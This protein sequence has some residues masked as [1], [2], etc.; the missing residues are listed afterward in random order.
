MS[1]IIARSPLR[2][3][4]GG[5]GTDLQSYYSK[6]GSHFVSAAISKFTYVIVKDSFLPGIHLKYSQQESCNTIDEVRHPLFREC[7]RVADIE[8]PRIEITSLADI[9]SGTGLGS[10]G[11]FTTAL[12]KALHAYKGIDIS[13]YELAD[14]AA[15]VEMKILGDPVGKQDPFISVFAGISSF[16]IDFEGRVEVSPLKLHTATLVQ[17]EENLHMF[18]TGITR[19]AKDILKDQE[20]KSNELEVQENLHSVKA[21]GFESKSLLEQGNIKEFA[22]NMTTQWE[23]KKNRSQFAS[24]THIDEAFQ[25]GLKSGAIGGKLIGAGGGGFLLFYAENSSRLRMA[26]AGVGL[27]EVK[28]QFEFQGTK[29]LVPK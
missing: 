27:L 13:N 3:S 12:L 8:N 10:S 15:L 6:F 20:L 14:L 5:G 24:T 9:P 21:L 1:L 28:F 25:L 2:I 26:M 7:L 19:R 17:L 16:T 23:K 11:S 18:Y 29:L 4:L 22:K